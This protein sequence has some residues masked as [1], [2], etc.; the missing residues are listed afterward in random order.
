[1]DWGYLTSWMLA[2]DSKK[3]KENPKQPQT[4][5]PFNKHNNFLKTSHL[6]WNSCIPIV[7]PQSH[8]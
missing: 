7:N 5:Q 4:T 6:Q 1:M 3:N 2:S 8:D